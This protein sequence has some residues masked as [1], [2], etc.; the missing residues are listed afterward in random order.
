MDLDEYRTFLEAE[1]D[2]LWITY[3]YVPQPQLANYRAEI[4]QAHFKASQVIL[5][6]WEIVNWESCVANSME[7]PL[8]SGPA[9]PASV[10]T[11]DQAGQLILAYWEALGGNTNETET[12]VDA[13]QLPESKAGL[14]AAILTVLEDPFDN[15]GPEER[16]GLRVL[17]RLLA[18]FQMGVGDTPVA[19]DRPAP[20][21]RSWRDVVAQEREALAA[22]LADAGF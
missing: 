8:Q 7:A 5:G 14:K 9:E 10:L 11:Q 2:I 15:D 16:E 20:D 18:G 19:L 17:F 22:E 6:P 1:E 21:C 13:S 12:V 3:S 4:E